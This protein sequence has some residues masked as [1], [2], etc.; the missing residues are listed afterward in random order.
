MYFDKP[1]K[2]NTDQTL[3]Y[4]AERGRELGLKEVV[5]ASSSG[6]TAYKAMEV[7]GGFQLTVVTYHCGF[8]EPFQNR[9]ADDVR[10]DIEAK[11]IRVIAASHA[12]S[13]IER[14][15]AQKHSGIYPV[16]LIADT[17]RLFGQGTKVAVEV[18]VMAADAGTLSGDDIVSIG[19]TGHGADAALI[20]K[21]A[22]QNNF[23]DLRIREV[24]CKP[25][26][27]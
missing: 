7:F 26:E 13:G 21:P 5:V 24:I 15:V 4:A 11:G 22:H 10:K 23:F 14:S 20:L 2:D 27:F 3:N 18:A 12:L 16:L 19:G 1:G 8:K 9:M 6:K 17:L 25:S